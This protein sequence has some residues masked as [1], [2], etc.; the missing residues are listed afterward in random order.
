M[1][2]KADAVASTGANPAAMPGSRLHLVRSD[3]IIDSER[4]IVF[5]VGIQLEQGRTFAVPVPDPYPDDASLE[6]A[7]KN[8]TDLVNASTDDWAHRLNDRHNRTW[9]ADFWRMLILP[10]QCEMI[11]RVHARWIALE[12]IAASA[13]AAGSIQ[14]RT[15]VGINRWPFDCLQSFQTSLIR[16]PTFNWWIDSTLLA[17]MADP[18]FVCEETE[19]DTA[20]PLPLPVARSAPI[21]RGR[22]LKLRLGHTDII[23]TRFGGL[24]LA[25]YANLLPRRGGSRPMQPAVEGGWEERFAPRMLEAL[26]VI[27]MATVPRTYWE[28]FEKLEA[29]GETFRYRTGRLRVGTIDYWNDQEKIVA[30]FAREAGEKFV[31]AQHGGFYG[32]MRYNVLATEGEYRYGRFFTWGFDVHDDYDSQLV[33]VPSPYLTRFSDRHSGKGDG[34]I[35]VGDPIRF[36]ITRIAPKPRNAQW[37]SYCDDTV[38]YLDRIDPAPRTDTLFRPYVNTATDITDEYVAARF[39]EIG[40]VTG[41]LHTRMLGCRL[42]TLCSPNTTMIVA[43]AANV[44]MVAFWRPEFFSLSA[45]ALPYFNRLRDVGILHDSPLAAAAKTNERW[46]NPDEWWRHPDRQAA[47]HEWVNRFARTHRFWWVWWMKE[48]WRAAREN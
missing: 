23:G 46:E 45:T 20:T 22:R 15:L 39:P 27:L 12:K 21:G 32:Q 37:L 9:S 42:L 14:V 36:G 24:L 44:P 33:A 38:Q 17:A 30:A 2:R 28:D 40:R 47:R 34:L 26:N 43:M 5:D 1:T 35:L 7:R 41:D 3:D 31:I 25:L 6:E 8:V 11:Q 10:W 4:D 19:W 48:L 18:A 16:D 13:P 29:V